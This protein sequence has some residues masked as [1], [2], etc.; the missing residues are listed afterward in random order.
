MVWWSAPSPSWGL[1]VWS[2][3]VLP[4]YAWVLT[5]PPSNNMHLRLT[6]DSKL[7]VC[8]CLSL[9]GPVMDPNLSRV[10]PASRPITAAGTN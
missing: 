4:V 3:H 7:S 8:G 2:L 6:G 9:C 1:S 10:N 5:L